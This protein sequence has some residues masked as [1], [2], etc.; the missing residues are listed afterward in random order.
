MLEYEEV[1]NYYK[2]ESDNYKPFYLNVSMEDIKNITN[3]IEKYCDSVCMYSRRIHNIN[4]VFEQ[5]ISNFNT[6][7]EINAC[8]KTN[9][10]EFHFKTRK[11][12][13]I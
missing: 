5:F 8:H 9:I 1:K 6:F 11:D 10:M 7:P 3:D 4:D 13:L 12:I 2:D